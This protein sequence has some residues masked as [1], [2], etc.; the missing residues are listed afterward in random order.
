MTHI[1]CTIQWYKDGSA[2]T[3]RTSN[4]LVIA[5]VEKLHEGQYW[6]ISTNVVGSTT[7][8]KATLTVITSIYHLFDCII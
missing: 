1:P 6:C 8:R 4:M 7:S 2:L 3:H 5:D